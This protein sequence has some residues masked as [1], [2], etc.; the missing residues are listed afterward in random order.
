MGK[1]HRLLPRRQRIAQFSSGIYSMPPPGVLILSEESEDA[2]EG[3][4]D[5][6]KW[7]WLVV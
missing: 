2:A 4:I 3:L 6:A 5:P 7:F 1:M